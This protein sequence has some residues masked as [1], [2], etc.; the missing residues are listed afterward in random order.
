M[1]PCV[2]QI[3][4]VVKMLCRKIAQLEFIVMY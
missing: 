1:L 2:V 4:F 3:I